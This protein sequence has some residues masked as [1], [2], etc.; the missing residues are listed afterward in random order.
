MQSEETLHAAFIGVHGANCERVP[1]GQ[2]SIGGGMVKAPPAPPGPTEL[3]VKTPPVAS[4]TSPQV[5]QA[6]LPKEPPSVALL[7]QACATPT[8]NGSRRTTKR[9]GEER[10]GS[11]RMGPILI[12]R[13]RT[14]TLG[15]LSARHASRSSPASTSASGTGL[16]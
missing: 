16:L 11:V 3:E 5:L 10:E 2:T 9:E 4:S 6:S 1:V 13:A 8:A 14:C 12:H 15:P 7:L